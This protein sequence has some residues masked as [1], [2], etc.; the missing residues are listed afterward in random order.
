VPHLPL[1]VNIAVALAL[2]L[3]GGLFARRIG[4]P[5]LVGYLLA[6]VAISP[7]SPIWVGDADA[8]TQLAELGVILLMFGIGLHFSFKDLWQVRDIAMPGAL[9]QMGLVAVLGWTMA[10][11]WGF[12]SGAAWVFG[13]AISV[14][15]TI[16]LLRGLMDHGW[17]DSQHGR[18]AVGWLVFED[19]A[20]VAILVLLPTLIG[21]SGEAWWVP[22][23]AILKAVLFVAL[24]I[25][26]GQRIVP[27]I[28]NRVVRTQSRELF[29][30]VALTLAAGTALASSAL[31]GVSLALGAFVAGVVVSESPFSHQVSADL[32]PFREAFAVLFFVSVGVLVNPGY[33]ITHWPQVLQTVVLVV[34]AKGA[35]SAAIG[36]LWPYPARTALILGAGRAQI[37][38]FS[39][40]V[41]QSGIALGLL[42][43][44]QYSL[45]LAAAI[46][47]I[48]I[49]PLLFRLV[50]PTERWLQSMP[51]LW[52]RLNRH[53]PA[54]RPPAETLSGHVVIVGSG[55]VG[56]HLNEVLAPLAVP[57]LVVEN[58]PARL[59]KLRSLG[60]PVLY[61]DA[62]SSEIL[63]HA[64][65]SRAR[66][67]VVTLPDDVSALAVVQYSRHLAPDLPIIVR[68]SSYDGAKRLREAGAT[69]IVRPEL[70]G[71]VAM[72]RQ[73]LL[74][75]D[76]AVN[77][78]ERYT[79]LV[80]REGMG[81]SEAPSAE[82]AR[83]LGDLM[84]AAKHVEIRWVSLEATS[85]LAGRSLKESALRTRAG[86]SVVAVV[87][88]S[89][90]IHNP[91]PDTRLEAG[92]RLALIGTPEQVLAALPLFQ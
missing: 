64:R 3:A 7:S 77:E 89:A 79:D 21:Q 12:T 70:E 59:D 26:V 45:I 30:L 50:G 57:R 43:Q 2:A 22:G 13:I 44:E 42:S 28:L 69:E 60:V 92:D 40:I 51:E 20:T 90:L 8:I 5:P 82:R 56:R 38:E 55:R 81:E 47:T 29:V 35:I 37:G 63:Q 34:V 85:S 41:G 48:T 9:L 75:L 67:L 24:M 65:L 46:I 74:D 91:D 49:N 39:F 31:F 53:G 10:S 27:A 78:I 52:R 71:G 19:I 73:T 33:V 58:D 84:R 76:L 6:G 86:V 23:W 11:A 87:R 4:L 17:L 83:L 54:V 80:R 18:V 32:L 16:V 62:A 1:I 61:G 88:N 72:V 66:L 68:A 25:V 15:S 36:F 14:A